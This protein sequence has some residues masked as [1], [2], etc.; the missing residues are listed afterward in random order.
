MSFNY[1][2]TLTERQMPTTWS[3]SAPDDVDD[4][5]VPPSGS[6]AP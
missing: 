5:E 4:D 3:E 1:D 6:S 2:L